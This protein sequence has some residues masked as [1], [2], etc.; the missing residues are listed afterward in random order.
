M[1]K[2]EKQY[3]VCID[4]EKAFDRVPR[5]VIWWARLIFDD[6]EW[7]VSVVKS[8]YENVRQNCVRVNGTFVEEFQVKVALHQ[9]TVLSHLLFIMASEALSQ[10]Y[11][12]VWSWEL[13]YADDL[14]LIAESMDK[15]IE[16]FNRWK[17][18][19]ESK[20][21]KVNIKKTEVMVSECDNV[22][23]LVR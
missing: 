15:V 22:D 16:K 11:K 12:V 7:F 10:K 14:V 3:F 1:S 21:L 13:F 9:G 20:R 8:M 19:I 18:G 4:L 2:N 17:E 6:L 5:E 23:Q